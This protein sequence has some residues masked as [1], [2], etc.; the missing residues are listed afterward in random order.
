MR[1]APGCCRAKDQHFS[2]ARPRIWTWIF[3]FTTPFPE[4]FRFLDPFEGVCHAR[5]AAVWVAATLRARPGSHLVDF[6]DFSLYKKKGGFSLYSKNAPFFAL[7]P[8]WRICPAKPGRQVSGDTT[9]CKITP[10]I[11][12]GAVSP[13]RGGGGEGR[14]GRHSSSVLEKV[15]QPRRAKHPPYNPTPTLSHSPCNQT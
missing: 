11:L 3:H 1:L 12:H 2:E 9:P 5:S 4:G 6:E 14:G 15:G 13:E 7:L 8:R 10:A